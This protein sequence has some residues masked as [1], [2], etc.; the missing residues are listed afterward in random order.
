MIRSRTDGIETNFPISRTGQW[1]GN[2]IP[3]VFGHVVS[4]KGQFPGTIVTQIKG[5][6]WLFNDILFNS[7]FEYRNSIVDTDRGKAHS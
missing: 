5:E 6:H 4:T 1:N 2:E 3:S 7:V